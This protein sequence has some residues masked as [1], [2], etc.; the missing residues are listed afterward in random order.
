MPVAAVAVLAVGI[1]LVGCI[2]RDIAYDVERSS[3]HGVWRVAY[4]GADVS[5]ILASDGTFTVEGWPR[6][7]ICQPSRVESMEELDWQD[8]VSFE[9]SWGAASS[10]LTYALDFSIDDPECGTRAWNSYVWSDGLGGLSLKV[11][12]D[13]VSDADTASSDQVVWLRKR[14]S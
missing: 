8:P 12:L 4:D 1:L 6:D 3:L 13:S 2:P 9:G 5:L 14:D 11:F 10:E 7:L